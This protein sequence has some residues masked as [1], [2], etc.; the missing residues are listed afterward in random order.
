MATLELDPTAGALDPTLL[1]NV[2]GFV[3]IAWGDL[4]PDAVLRAPTSL[5]GGDR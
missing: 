3:T 1:H 2:A 5:A 4:L